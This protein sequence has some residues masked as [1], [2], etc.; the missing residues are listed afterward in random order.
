MT[1]TNKSAKL[2]LTV[3]AELARRAELQEIR[4]ELLFNAQLAQKLEEEARK[5]KQRDREL[6][7]RVLVLTQD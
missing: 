6:A 3:E 1:T 7:Q 5:L 2:V 4:R